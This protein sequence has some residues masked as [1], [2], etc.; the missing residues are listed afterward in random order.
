MLRIA[1][2]AN[3][4]RPDPHSYYKQGQ[5][6][7]K[8]LDWRVE[9]DFAKRVLRGVASLSF[10]GSGH[11]DLDTRD[12]TIT[13]V[14][15]LFTRKKIPYSLGERDKLLGSRLSFEVPA[16]NFVAITYVTSPKASGLQWLTPKQAG[17]E[18]P[19]VYS[20]GQ[21]IHARSYLPCQ[22]TPGIKFT[23]NAT[24]TVPKGLQ[25]LVAANR[26]R[27]SSSNG[28]VASTTW[29]MEFPI[30]SY[31]VAFAAGQLHYRDISDKHRVWAQPH[32]IARAAAQYANLPELMAAGVKLAGEYPFGRYD[33]L[34]LP[35]AFP[36]GG[37]ENPCLTFLTPMV[38]WTDRPTRNRLV[39]HELAHS[40]P[41]NLVTNRTWRHFWLNEGWTSYV[42]WRILT[43][44]DGEEVANLFLQNGL[45]GLQRDFDRWW[46]VGRPYMSTLTPDV[47]TTDPDEAFSTVPYI[48]GLMFLRCLEEQVGGDKFDDFMRAYIQ[49][50][51]YGTID[52]SQFLAFAASYLPLGTL[53]QCRVWDWINEPDMPTNAPSTPSMLAHTVTELAKN[54]QLPRV[55][56]AKCW[57][58]A[59]WQLYFELLP[60]TISAKKLQLLMQRF[61]PHLSE[62]PNIQYAFCL[63]AIES[64]HTDYVKKEVREL[65]T[66]YGNIMYVRRLYGALCATPAGTKLAKE[67]FAHARAGY[68]PISVTVAKSAIRAAEKKN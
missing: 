49:K 20:Q 25:G 44:L 5:P 24:V 7:I 67:I 11:V 14:V 21:A 29:D 31:L 57:I 41:G 35:K 6:Q 56:Q 65:L 27:G 26:F 10:T 36:Y 52:T 33:L 64:G 30:P 22:D 43:E 60:R 37:M 61:T 9:V 59:E 54:A 58:A 16:S 48:K 2:V 68:H 12:V 42:E 34:F 3:G 23:F 15:N 39:G 8:H 50:F 47:S 1:H 40:W 4:R 51:K 28:S 63:L 53:E 45:R 19:F 17:N 62:N 18:F 66:E 55:E 13:S 38:L 46:N 32:L